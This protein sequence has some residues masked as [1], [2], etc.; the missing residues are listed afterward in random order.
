MTRMLFF[1]SRSD[2]STSLTRGKYSTDRLQVQV[3]SD[4]AA[5]ELR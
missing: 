5:E 3:S 2:R 1:A 4:E